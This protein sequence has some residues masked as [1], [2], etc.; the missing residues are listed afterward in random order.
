LYTLF[1]GFA[2]LDNLIKMR[3]SSHIHHMNIV[4][5]RHRGEKPRKSPAI[6][7]YMDLA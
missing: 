6:S 3:F 2:E 5:L 7:G 4:Y 1:D